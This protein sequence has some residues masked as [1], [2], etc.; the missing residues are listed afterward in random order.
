[1]VKATVAWV[2]T[3]EPSAHPAFFNEISGVVVSQAA[4]AKLAQS[5]R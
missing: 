5:S 1:M 2:F 4:R 3:D